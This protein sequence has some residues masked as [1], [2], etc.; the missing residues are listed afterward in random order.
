M[1]GLKFTPITSQDDTITPE[2]RR[3]P[4]EI[5]YKTVENQNYSSSPGTL[6]EQCNTIN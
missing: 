4:T 6:F 3:V 2:G 5:M 1:G